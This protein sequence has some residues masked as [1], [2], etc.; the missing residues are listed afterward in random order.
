MSKPI[1]AIVGRPNVGKSML[2]NK[3]IGKRLSIVEDTPAANL[4]SLPGKDRLSYTVACCEGSCQWLLQLYA[5]LYTLPFRRWPGDRI[6]RNQRNRTHRTALYRRLLQL[7]PQ[8]CQPLRWIGGKA[9]LI[10]SLVIRPIIAILQCHRHQ[11][12]ALL[13]R[14]AYQRPRNGSL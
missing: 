5:G 11:P 12:L 9:I 14:A 6:R 7:L 8:R 4:L 3:L 13:F 10:E 2:F 1:V